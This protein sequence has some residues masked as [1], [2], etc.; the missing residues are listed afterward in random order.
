[1]GS[2]LD[3]AA[4]DSRYRS[5]DIARDIFAAVRI[6]VVTTTG[7]RRHLSPSPHPIRFSTTIDHSCSR[8][9]PK[10]IEAVSGSGEVEYGL[11]LSRARI[12]CPPP[13]Q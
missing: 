2:E 4:C 12:T 8:S 9:F 1:M 10:R 11:G 5:S 3:E 6:G 13:E 7:S